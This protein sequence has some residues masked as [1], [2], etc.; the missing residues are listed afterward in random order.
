[1]DHLDQHIEACLQGDMNRFE[2]VVKLYE[3]KVR[4]VLAAMIPDS[5][6]V[7]DLTQEVFLVAYR[8]LSSYRS[9]TNFSAWISTIARNVAQNERRRWYRQ[10]HMHEGYKAET[11]RRLVENIDRFVESLP[12]DSLAA[13]QECVGGMAGRTRAIVDGFYYDRCS[14]KE[15]A[16]ILKLSSNAAKV[17]L[18][19]A[20]RALGDCVQKK[21]GRDV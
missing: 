16:D 7:S 8:R 14:I 13:L 12:D 3:P 17:A 18:H 2:E 11:E 15:I 9:G 1:M 21:G 10:Q 20:R 19:R 4:A 6:Q 5:G